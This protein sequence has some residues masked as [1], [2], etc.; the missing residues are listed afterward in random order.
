MRRQATCNLLTTLPYPPWPKSLNRRVYMTPGGEELVPFHIHV[1]PSCTSTVASQHSATLSTF[2][3]LLEELQL[4][5]LTMCSAS[6]LF[7]L[8]HTSSKLRIEA[9]KLFW[10]RRNVYFLV[11][12]QWLLDHA[13]PGQSYWDMAFLAN[14]QN[15]QVDCSPTLSRKI[16]PKRGETR[17][18]QHTLLHVFWT[19]LQ[20][21]FPNLKSVIINHNEERTSW[22][23]EKEPFPLALQLLLR[24]CPQYITSSVLF[25]EMMPQGTVSRMDWRTATWQRCLFQ[26]TETGDWRK[27][28]PESTS[29][30]V[31]MPP[32]KFNGPVGRFSNMEY[33][34]YY[35]IRLQRFGLWPLMVEALDRHHF[36]LGRSTSF[37]CPLSGCTAYFYQA[38]EWTV[39]AATQHYQ[40]WESLL[41]VLPST[42]AGA[43]LR[44]R[45]KA[46]DQ[47]TA[48]VHAQYSE[49]RNA[50]TLSNET[51][52]GEIKRSWIEQIDSDAAWETEEK[53]E[54][55]RL[56]QDF[57]E[58]LYPSY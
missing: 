24:A 36:D 48:E 41:E 56:W 15:V 4:H 25:L 11:E 22:D 32:K 16:C 44:E 47:K 12:A 17:Q 58:S 2:L 38:G 3:K 57:I 49:I 35:T 28:K 27:S 52:Q 46:L 43:E 23:D 1:R 30:T 45:C 40:E 50:W 14:V 13:Y 37:A 8:M 51:I 29:K 21:R 20:N 19:S 26:Q 6:S 5:I 39:H 55:S 31:I 7:Q 10:G 54:K 9:S 33:Q 42:S 18:I 34:L 53:G